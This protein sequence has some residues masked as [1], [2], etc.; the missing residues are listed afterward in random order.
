V[1]RKDNLKFLIWIGLTGIALS[2]QRFDLRFLRLFRADLP[3]RKSSS[4]FP[5]L[6]AA[7]SQR[8][9]APRPAQVSPANHGNPL[10]L[11]D[12]L[13]MLNQ[14]FINPHSQV[15]ECFNGHP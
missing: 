8:G 3:I 5:R 6:I 10:K 2:H 1:C 9:L 15:H 7:T 11:L 12:K 4:F 13:G 14:H